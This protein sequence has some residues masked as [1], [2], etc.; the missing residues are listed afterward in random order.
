MSIEIAPPIAPVKV[1]SA[2]EAA[3]AKEKSTAPEKSQMADPAG[4]MAILASLENTSSVPLPDASAPIAAEAAMDLRAPEMS[5]A[6]PQDATS[7]LAQALQWAVPSDTLSAEVEGLDGV[8]A[9][10]VGAAVGVQGLSVIEA[11]PKPQPGPLVI[12]AVPKPQSGPL[13]IEAAV[14]SELGQKSDGGLH[15]DA[16]LDAKRIIVGSAAQRKELNDS[17]DTA[18]LQSLSGVEGTAP[19]L[20][21]R[22]TDGRDV[23]FSP[24][25]LTAKVVPPAAG[26]SASMVFGT[27]KQEE[28]GPLHG[29]FQVNHNHDVVGLANPSGWIGSGVGFA[30]MSTP[31]A[32]VATTPSAIAQQV[33][34]WISNDVQKAE[35]KLE[36]LGD[37]PVEVTISMNGNQ[38]HVAFR[39]DEV[40]ARD[41]LENA[42]LQLKEMLQRDG[43][44]LS[45][46]SVG[47]SAGGET[48]S[49]AQQNPNARRG[50]V[51][52]VAMVDKPTR[53]DG[54][55]TGHT[56]V[57]RALDLFV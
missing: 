21:A 52:V 20:D 44:V 42:S 13:V 24:A 53:L 36:G 19:A 47:T 49:G 45:G 26:A 54:A 35:M 9:Q 39:T 48:G 37:T 41:A 1:A 50:H 25:E 10:V 4:F 7:L 12:E 34:Y 27:A 29:L 6:A 16:V 43:V 57:G 8:S 17:M 56:T 38:A 51:N 18:A 22:R 14:T 3:G 40:Q 30:T 5:G 15:L 28:R 46:M 33:S 2:N 32:A 23:K 31:D 11:V 55:K